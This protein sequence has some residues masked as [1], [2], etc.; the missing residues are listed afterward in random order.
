MAEDAA[1]PESEP[2]ARPRNPLLAAVLSALLPGLGQV[3][4]GDWQKG[5]VFFATFLALPLLAPLYLGSG[6]LILAIVPPLLVVA[7]AVIDAAGAARRKGRTFVPCAWNRGL[8]LIGIYVLGALGMSFISDLTKQHLFRPYRMPAES[9]RPT[10]LIGD[11]FLADVTAPARVPER[12]KLV[13][14]RFPLDRGKD[15]IMRI[16]AVAGDTL[17]IRDKVVYVNGAALD[18]PYVMR[19]DPIVRPATETPRDN[20]APAAIPE[21]GVFVLGDFRDN[22]ND[23]RYWGALPVEDIIGVP[24]QI[25]WSWDE[26][27]SRIRWGRI[28]RM[29]D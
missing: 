14:F 7:S 8:V 13:V 27:A 3:Y 10:L 6:F 22:S 23:S 9:M 24:R 5:V 2:R 26:D 11:Y 12:G 19:T 29:L 21:G 16:L 4:N 17:E 18:E 20:F 28:G 15:F 25:Y 1:R